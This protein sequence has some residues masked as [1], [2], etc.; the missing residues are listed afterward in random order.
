M[1]AATVIILLILIA[2]VCLVIRSMI[3]D[4]KNGG[5][6]AGCAGCGGS[7]SGCGSKIEPTKAQGTKR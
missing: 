4:R 1:N 6:C 2:V 5:G 7:C 3:R